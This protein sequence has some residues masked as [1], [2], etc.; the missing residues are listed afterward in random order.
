M[1]FRNQKYI[2][3]YN[4]VKWRPFSNIP[5][6]GAG[7]NQQKDNHIIVTD[8]SPSSDPIDGTLGLR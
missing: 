1:S 6:P 4:Y 8:E 3:S 5:Q 2:K 7:E